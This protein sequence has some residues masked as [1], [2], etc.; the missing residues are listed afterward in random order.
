MRRRLK[1]VTVTVATAVMLGLSSLG[2]YGFAEPPV[3]RLALPTDLVDVASVEGRRL[4]AG[5]VAQTDYQ[6]LLPHFVSQSRRA[7]CG[8]ATGSM[9][10]NAE[11]RPQ[12]P[13]TQ[14][15]FFGTDAAGIRTNLMVTL[16]GMTLDELAQY[17]RSRGLRVQVMHAAESNLQA[18]RDLA[19]AALSEPGEM[20][21]VNYDRRRLGQEGA[22]HISPVGAYN[23]DADRLLV[24]DVAAY[25]Y[26]FTW[27]PLRELWAAMDT[28]DADSGQTRGFLL[29]RRADTASSDVRATSGR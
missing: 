25:R 4:L 16:R 9:I 22:G 6:Q 21:V 12:A 23:G 13:V 26:P 19:R 3:Q 24:M 20:L 17:L 7:F 1:A 5:A 2:W 15:A 10:V 27:V 28:V 18:F 11:L 29:V 14:A 8:A